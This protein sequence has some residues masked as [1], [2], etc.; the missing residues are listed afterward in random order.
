[1]KNVVGGKV[2]MNELDEVVS[3]LDSLSKCC[4]MR[5]LINLMSSCLVGPVIL[6][7]NMS[8]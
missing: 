4:A 8:E 2:A 5:F 7:A 1:M 6:F 3:L